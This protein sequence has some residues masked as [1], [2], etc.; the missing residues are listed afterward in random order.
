MNETKVINMNLSLY[1]E[2][3]NI[4]CRHARTMLMMY[5]ATSDRKYI[6]QARIDISNVR[7]ILRGGH[8]R[9]LGVLLLKSA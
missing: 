2:Q 4:L 7:S 8:M 3:A 9:P 5:R 1:N 6:H